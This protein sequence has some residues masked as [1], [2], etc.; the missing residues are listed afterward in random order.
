MH[1]I[2][3]E[4][5]SITLILVNWVQRNGL[6]LNLK[7]INYMYFPKK[8]DTSSVQITNDGTEKPNF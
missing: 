4:L 5:S 8:V 2:T 7:K 1:E 6:V 3:E